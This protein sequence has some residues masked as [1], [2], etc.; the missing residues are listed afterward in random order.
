[1]VVEESL[2]KHNKGIIWAQMLLGRIVKVDWHP[3][4]YDRYWDRQYVARV[5]D[6][7]HEQLRAQK[8]LI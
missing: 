6:I 4:N 5:V 3:N 2:L 8:F 7:S 1:M